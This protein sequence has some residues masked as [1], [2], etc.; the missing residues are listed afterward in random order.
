MPADRQDL[1][2]DSGERLTDIR[3]AELRRE[4]QVLGRRQPRLHRVLVADIGH[5]PRMRRQIGQRILPI[6]GQPTRRRA[7]A[8]RRATAAAWTCLTRSDRSAAAPRQRRPRGQVAEYQPFATECRQAGRLQQV[9][10]PSSP[11]GRWRRLVCKTR[12][13][14]PL[15]PR[16][17][18]ST[19]PHNGRRPT[20]RDTHMKA[21]GQ[22]TLK[23]RRTL[24]VQGKQYDYFSL[25]EAAKSLGDITRLPVTLKILLENVLRFEDGTSYTVEDA[26]SIAG[27]LAP[28]TP[29]KEVPFKPARILLQDFTG[30]PAVVDLAAMRDGITRLGSNPQKVNP[31]VPVDLV[32]DHSVIVDVV[33]ATR[34]ADPQRRHR[35]RAQRRALPFPALG[36]ERVRQ[37]PRRAT[38]HG[39]LPPGEPGISRAVR[40]DRRRRTARR[41]PIPTRCTAPT[42]TPRW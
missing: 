23:T 34:R 5:A 35:V 32:I 7:A 25:P 30:V 36:P 21:I 17:A 39:H 15:H 20:G 3:T 24:T 13:Q 26:K 27:W 38:G 12:S 18:P 8:A 11:G 10:C 42:A 9:T 40:V 14:Q 19:V 4:L 6:P 41:S 29:T 33:G 28:R 22:D 37:F 1:Q 2:P 16:H 31:L